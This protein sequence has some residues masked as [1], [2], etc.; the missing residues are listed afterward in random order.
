MYTGSVRQNVLGPG[1][2]TRT[3]FLRGRQ[4]FTAEDYDQ[5]IRI[6][7]D[8]RGGI[9]FGIRKTLLHFGA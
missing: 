2:M 4:I 9:V 1:N 7:Q 3:L 6:N 5:V 8:T